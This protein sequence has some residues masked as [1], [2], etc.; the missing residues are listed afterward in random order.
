MVEKTYDRVYYGG[1]KFEQ[2]SS[3]TID[4]LLF[5]FAACR[6]CIDYDRCNQNFRPEGSCDDCLEAAKQMIAEMFAKGIQISRG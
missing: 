2:K 4:D 3:V 1:T 6:G 5:D